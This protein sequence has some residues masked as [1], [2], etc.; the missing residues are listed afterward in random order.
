M[1][2]AFFNSLWT[3]CT[4]TPWL[5]SIGHA[6]AEGGLPA[7]LFLMGLIGGVVHCTG[8][9]GP[10]VLAQVTADAGRNLQQAPSE[11]RRLQGAALLPYQLGRMTTYSVLGGIAGTLG[12]LVVALSGY[13]WALGILLACAA[14]MFFVQAIAGFTRVFGNPLGVVLAGPLARIARPLLNDSRGFRGYLLGL[15][16]GFLPCGFLYGA[17]TAAAG[18]GS[19]WRGALA[20]AAFTL[21]TIPNLML[22]GYVG[23]FFRQR[24]AAAAHGISI[25]LMI[26]NAGFLGFLAARALG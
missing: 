3:F 14:A 15:A 24:A 22:V 6:M 5:A 17:L 4:D 13:R 8:M 18:S 23:V 9:C 2:D 25:P 19:A 21:G 12:E 11:W 1:F 20:M 10:F 26:A 16:L 7:A